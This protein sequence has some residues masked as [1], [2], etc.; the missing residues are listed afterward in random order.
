MRTIAFDTETYYDEIV[1]VTKLGNYNYCR[2]PKFQLMLVSVTDGTE[3]WAG[4][5]GDFNWDSLNGAHLVSHNAGF[6][7]E[8]VRAEQERGNIPKLNL[9]GWD[10]SADMSACLAKRRSLAAAIEFYYGERLAKNVR[11]NMSGK[12]L[13]DLRA[14]GTLDETLRYA[15]ADAVWTHKLWTDQSPRWSD[16]ERRL[17]RHTRLMCQRGIHVD[18][19]RVAADEATLREALARCEK[20]L[21]WVAAGKPPTST[22]AAAYKCREVGIPEPPVKAHDG[23]EEAFAEWETEYG[24][25]YP[26]IAAIGRWRS[27]NKMLPVIETLKARIRPDGI[28]SYDLLYAGAHTLRASARGYN[29]LNMRKEPLCFSDDY[30]WLDL[31]AD[32]RQPDC[33]KHAVDQRSWFVPPPGHKFAIVDSAQIEP[34]IVHWYAGNERLLGLVRRG[35][36][37]YDAYARSVNWY[38]DPTPLKENK[39]QA[40]LY[41]MA[42]SVV[43]GASYGIGAKKFKETAR[44]LAGLDLSPE[45]AFDVVSAFRRENPEVV[46][47]WDRLTRDFEASVGGDYTVVLPSGREMVYK[48]VSR[49]TRITRDPNTKLPR[50]RAV[51]TAEF[52]HEKTQRIVREALWGG[53]LLENITQA[54]ARD[55]FLGQVLDVEQRLGYPCHLHVYD[56]NVCVVPEQG[57]DAALEAVIQAHSTTPEWAPGL[58]LS[59]AGGTAERYLK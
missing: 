39:A 17:S 2:H 50:R 14:G 43:I 24:P 38:T 53:S 49:E 16:F 22:L 21:P 5:P 52:F 32:N 4:L 27:I 37:I 51:T 20:E 47:L 26:W 29:V 3:S 15:L 7:S 28:L 55:I 1:S 44:K 13:A 57:A 19:A 46:G 54:F 18:M 56:E 48:N 33:T 42:K 25:K 9:A 11:D 36:Q 59:A 34:R 35:Y 8:V 58:P 6:D 23:G 30:S 10:C 45:Q 41:R 40:A 12:S 31:T